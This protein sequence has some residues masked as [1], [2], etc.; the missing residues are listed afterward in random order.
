M[1][2]TQNMELQY[3]IFFPPLLLQNSLAVSIPDWR[4][5]TWRNCMGIG[6]QTT[7]QDLLKVI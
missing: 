4:E 3:N 6:A 7:K 1:D 2:A 5:C